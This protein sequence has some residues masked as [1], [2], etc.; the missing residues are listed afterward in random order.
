MSVNNKRIFYVKYLAHPIYA[1][2]MKA[3]GDVRFDRLENETTEAVYA[4]IL[5]EAHAYQIGAA[6]DEIA[7]HFHAHAEL[8]KR[9]PKLLVVS[10][11]GA[12]F[13]PVDVEACTKAGFKVERSEVRLG[14]GPLRTLG[15]HVVN[16]HLHADVD[17][18]LAVS[19]VAEE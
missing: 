4:P 10:S 14:S 15:E 9:A 2:I 8:L 6:R 11:N 18:P 1:D 12:G 16:L 13:D 3:R 19:I 17:I 7:P 5:A